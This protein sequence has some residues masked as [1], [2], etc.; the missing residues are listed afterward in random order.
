MMLARLMCGVTKSAARAVARQEAAV[1]ASLRPLCSSTPKM[2]SAGQDA[3]TVIFK[4]T[5]GGQQECKARVGQN[6]L[7]VAIDNDIDLE[8][9][10]ACRS[11]S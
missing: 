7:D 2:S 3:V 9:Q 10:P 6:L 4:D 5:S 11:L 8:G 1:C